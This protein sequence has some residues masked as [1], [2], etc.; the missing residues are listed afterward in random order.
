MDFLNNLPLDR[1]EDLILGFVVSQ[2]YLAPVLLLF[3]EETGIPLPTADF[4]IAYT[5]YQVSLG[6]LSFFVAFL[7]L[8]I[9]DLLGASILYFLCSRYGVHVIN[10]FGKFI[11][12]DQN[13]LDYVEEKFRKYGALFIIFGRHIPGFRIP[14]TVFSGISEMSYLTFIGSTFISIV[15]W[16]SFY[17]SLGQR[18]GPR[19]VHLLHTH[20][21]YGLL[22]LLPIAIFIAPFIFLRKSKKAK[23]EV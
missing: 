3:L 22:F 12:L 8:M 19:T 13:K 1:F 6:H 15:F 21:W 16:I 14:I 20:G 11:D 7:I 18:L 5:G 23:K 2:S 17:L 4:V 9:A 10:I